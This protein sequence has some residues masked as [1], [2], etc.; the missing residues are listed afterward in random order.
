MAM[1][2][3]QIYSSGVSEVVKALTESENTVMCLAI[4]LVVVRGGH[5]LL[6]Q[7]VLDKL[8]PEV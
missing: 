2:G 3:Y 1:L 5:L 7:N 6:D 4:S 8:L